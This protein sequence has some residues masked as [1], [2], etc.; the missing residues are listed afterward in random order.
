M[1]GAIICSHMKSIIFELESDMIK[2][3][4]VFL[5]DELVPVQE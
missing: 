4:E 3:L 5:E 2:K 1:A